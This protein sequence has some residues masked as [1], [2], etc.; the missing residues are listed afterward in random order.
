MSKFFFCKEC[1][2]EVPRKANSQRYCEACA[3]EKKRQQQRKKYVSK[4]VPKEGAT[5]GNGHG[6]WDLRGKSL[7]EIALEARALGMSY[8]EYVNA[9]NSGSMK[10]ILLQ[11]GIS[12]QTARALIRKAKAEKTKKGKKTT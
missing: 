12:V 3:A 4:Y 9:C 6:T 1:G 7:S 8:G 5:Y 10:A 11:R 2:I